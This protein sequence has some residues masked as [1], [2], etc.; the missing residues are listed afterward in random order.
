LAKYT[1]EFVE[2]CYKQNLLIKNKMRIEGT[3]DNSDDKDHNNVI[4]NLKNV[5]MPFLNVV[6]EKDDLVA[7]ESSKALVEALTG[8]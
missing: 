7:P 3:A 8:S 6:A 5:N 4:I 1:G 2:Y